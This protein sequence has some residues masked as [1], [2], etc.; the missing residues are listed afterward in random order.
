MKELLEIIHSFDIDL[1]FEDVIK[2]LENLRDV[3][4]DETK[5]LLNLSLIDYF[6]PF[7][8]EKSIFY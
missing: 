7:V 3:C 2:I 8:I 4:D 1:E 6:Y 5:E